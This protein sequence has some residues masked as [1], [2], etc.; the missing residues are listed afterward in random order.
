MNDT[1]RLEL[2]IDAIIKETPDSF[3]YY[4]SADEPVNYKAGQFLTILFDING[5]NV[6][7]SYSLGSTLGIDEKMFIT[8]KRKTNGEVSRYMQDHFETGHTLDALSPAGR[9]IIDEIPADQYVFF[10]AGS[11]IVP[12]FSLIK[13]LLYHYPETTV[14]LFYQCRTENEVI[15]YRS[16][17]ALKEKFTSRFS[18]SFYYSQPIGNNRA[19]RMNNF[20]VE[21]I[22][23]QFHSTE[24]T[25]FYTCGPEAYMRMVQFTLRSNNVDDADIR[26]EN[27]VIPEPFIPK[28]IDISPKQI[29]VNYQGRI[30]KYTATYPQTILSAALAVGIELPYS[31]RG[32]R[33][34]SCMA[35]CKKGSVKMSVNDVLTNRDL[36]NNYILTCTAHA[37][38]D[39]EIK[40]P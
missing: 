11:G 26:K 38:T 22:L 17:E 10:A 20:M 2:R 25:K 16:I 13:E 9:F 36:E 4:F 33:C 23:K 35:I 18:V 28:D 32:G 15:Y 34:S 27:F 8:V 7:R 6:R 19:V 14:N 31:C 1:G 21:S 24:N 37:E 39:V 40:Y 30:H 3:S 29:T 5:R 12:V